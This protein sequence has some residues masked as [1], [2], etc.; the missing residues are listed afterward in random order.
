MSSLVKPAVYVVP[1][2]P[3]SSS[4]ST[5]DLGIDG[6][7][8]WSTL[9]QGV[10]P[11][12]AGTTHILYK[13]SQNNSK[14]DITALTSLGPSFSKPHTSVDARRELVRTAVGKAVQQIK[15]LGEG[16]HGTEVLVDVSGETQAA[17]VAAYLAAYSF[18]L[19][20]DPPSPYSPSS[21]SLNSPEK[22]SFKA[23]DGKSGEWDEGKV[24][25]DAQNLARTLMELPANMLTP[26][27]F[28][29]RIRKESEG[30]NGVE[31]IARDREWAEK[32]GM[33]S[34]LSVSNGT[35]EPPKFLEIH[36]R[37]ATIKSE[38]PLILVG[39]GIT[40]D[41]GGISLKPSAGMKLMR[42]DMGGAATVCATVLAV[43][44]LKIPINLTVV[45]PLTENMPGPSA[46]KPG[47]IVYAMNGMSIEIDNTDAEGRLVLADALYYACKEYKPDTIVDVATLTGAMDIALGEIYTGVFTNSDSLW[48]ELNGAGEREHDRFWRMPLSEDYA[49][50]IRGSN[51]DLCNTGGKPAGSCTAAL[52]LKSF[53]PDVDADA[54]GEQE[55]L[56]WAHVDMAGTMEA[57][58]KGPYQELGMTGRPTR[59]AL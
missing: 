8:L 55:K 56:R 3:T 38:T 23:G 32:K 28:V 34:F 17:A 57:T 1:V 18:N 52:F 7:K 5:S 21:S 36:Y 19:K 44:K 31:V 29:E 20:T 16:V 11:A 45:T 46:S 22:F 26:T 4:S 59:S 25:A 40:F 51:A 41:S 14:S 49:P 53:V 35:S 6:A 27:L 42:A 10:K 50:Q 2:D 33:H 13:P 9:P 30:L 58:R 48:A 24:Y 37:G 54:E 15:G 43:A 39:K 47:D 12:K